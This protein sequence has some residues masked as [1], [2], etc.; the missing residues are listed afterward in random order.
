LTAYV[1][2]TIE[3]V[4]V[5]R[6]SDHP[7]AP[8]KRAG[9]EPAGLI[10]LGDRGATDGHLER[11]MKKTTKS[12]STADLDAA[13]GTVTAGSRWREI[14]GE[15]RAVTIRR[16]GHTTL[17]RPFVFFT[18]DSGR[19]ANRMAL[20]FLHAYR[21]ECGKT[22]VGVDE[23]DCGVTGPCV[24]SPG[25]EGQCSLVSVCGRVAGDF[26]CDRPSLH[27]GLHADGAT[28]TWRDDDTRVACS[29]RGELER[30]LDRALKRERA[31]ERE[32]CAKFLEETA[33]KRG[34]VR[35]ETLL[36]AARLIRERERGGSQ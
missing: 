17:G 4:T 30:A 5:G 36:W 31:D 14:G 29:S 23:D 35:Q 19:R 24:L 34:G 21:H 22:A 15:R 12:M 3:R 32:A 10:S 7:G 16:I 20:D 27:T 13:L 26:V 25:H 18:Y 9:I 8:R 6:A 33:V 11:S 1:I 2:R 28:R